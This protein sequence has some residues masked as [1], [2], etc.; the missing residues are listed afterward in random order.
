MSSAWLPGFSLVRLTKWLELGTIFNNRWSSNRCRAAGWDPG[1]AQLCVWE[2][3]SDYSVH[4][5]P[6]SGEAPGLALQTGE[7]MG[8]TLCSSATVQRAVGLAVRSPLSFG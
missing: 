6:W 3:K 7:A 5:I 4:L 2:P 1:T 8:C